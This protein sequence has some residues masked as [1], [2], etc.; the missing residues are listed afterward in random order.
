M[1]QARLSF[2]APHLLPPFWAL[3][4]TERVRDW[5]PMAQE[6]VHALQLLQ[7]VATQSTGQAWAL[8]RRELLEGPQ[9]APP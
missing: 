6:T 2:I 9:A 4:V 1:S 3:L 7:P 5:L 8:Q